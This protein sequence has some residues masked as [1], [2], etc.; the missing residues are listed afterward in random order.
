[1]KAILLC[2]L[3]LLA[4]AGVGRSDDQPARADVPAPELFGPHWLNTPDGKPITLASRRGKVTVVEFWTF[5]CINCRHNLPAYAHWQQQFANRD[6][7]IIGVHTPET[8]EERDPANVARA[9]KQLGISY[10]VLL[11]TDA[12]NWN[13]WHQRYWPAVYLVDSRGRI[14]Y[15]WAGE[16]NYGGAGGEAKMARLIEELLAEAS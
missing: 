6:V 14:R 12:T 8:D 9:V 11:D 10:P 2:L 5:A 3:V 13:R 1:M 16:L 15:G 7:E 4:Y